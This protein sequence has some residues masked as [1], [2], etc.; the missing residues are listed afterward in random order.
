MVGM[1]GT[2]DAVLQSQGEHAWHR[3]RMLVYQQ[4]AVCAD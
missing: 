1:S 2:Q 3:Q 4:N